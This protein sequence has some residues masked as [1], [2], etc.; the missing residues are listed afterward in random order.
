MADK[1]DTLNTGTNNVIP[2][3]LVSRDVTPSPSTDDTVAQLNEIIEQ[4]KTGRLTSLVTFALTSDG[5]LTQILLSK[6]RFELLGLAR[7]AQS[8]VDG[9]LLS[10]TN[11]D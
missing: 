10:T 1:N 8:L 6:N 11:Q 4:V 3:T 7:A 9:K 5:A 2:L